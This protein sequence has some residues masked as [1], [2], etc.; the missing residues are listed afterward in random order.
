MNKIINNGAVEYEIL[1]IGNDINEN[2]RKKNKKLVKN[3]WNCWW[4]NLKIFA[5]T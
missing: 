1:L 3:M 2:K 4:K 5:V